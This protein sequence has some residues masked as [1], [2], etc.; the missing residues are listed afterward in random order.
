MICLRTNN[1]E[2]KAVIEE[3][4]IY[5][6]IYENPTKNMI[7][8]R[9]FKSCFESVFTPKPPTLSPPSMVSFPVSLDS[10]LKLGRCHSSGFFKGAQKSGF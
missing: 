7:S 8:F 5:G 10:T 1:L 2:S 3:L 9:N 6:R 4:V